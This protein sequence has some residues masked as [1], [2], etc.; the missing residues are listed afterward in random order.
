MSLNS[1]KKRQKVNRKVNAEKICCEIRFFYDL[2]P[3]LNQFRRQNRRENEPEA[4]HRENR[5]NLTKHWQGQ[6][7]SRFGLP[8]NDEK[9]FEKRFGRRLRKRSAPKREKSDF[10][11]SRGSIREPK[12]RIFRSFL[13]NFSKLVSR[14]Y[15]SHRDPSQGSGPWS[16]ATVSRILQ[17]IRSA[18]SVYLLIAPRR[19][20]PQRNFFDGSRKSV[21][22]H[23]KF[24]ETSLKSNKNCPKIDKIQQTLV[25]ININQHRFSLFPIFLDFWTFLDLQ[26]DLQIHEKTPKSRSKS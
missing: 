13:R 1:T 17:R 4:E 18:L 15:S 8:K 23:R 5:K 11:S 24:R 26:N 2:A 9:S 22:M 21:K 10:R 3:F 6:Q 14:G 20:N 19:P 16:F 7:K 25:L 12:N